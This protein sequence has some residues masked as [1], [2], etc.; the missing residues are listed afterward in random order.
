MVHPDSRDMPVS[1]AHDATT[2]VL[3][4]K[5]LRKS[6][7]LQ[8]TGDY[9]RPFGRRCIVSGGRR[10]L[11]VAGDALC[12]S[13]DASGVRVGV[14]LFEGQ[15][16]QENI[17]TIVATCLDHNAE[18]VVGVGGGR[19]LDSAK[20]AA[21]ALR[22][23]II[24]VPTVASTCSAATPAVVLYDAEGRF[25]R[26]MTLPDAPN[27]VMVDP[28]LIADAPVEYFTP[29][30]LDALSKWYEME[31]I[32]AH[33][34]G[35]DLHTNGAM[36]LAL[37]LRDTVHEKGVSAIE[38]V[39]R[40]TVTADLLEMIDLC[41]YQTAL[42]KC[43]SLSTLRIG[44]AHAVY[45]ALTCVPAA[46]SHMHGTIVGYGMALQLSAL[47]SGDEALRPVLALFQE[48]GSVPSLE[49]L[50]VSPTRE[51]TDLLIERCMSDPGIGAMPQSITTATLQYAIDH[52]ESLA[53]RP[54]TR[55]V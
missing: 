24:C 3:P 4:A 7:I 20:A 30:I 41:I 12:E 9:V 33:M 6:G 48:L 21:S 52:V 42:I 37:L 40:N 43:L 38:A 25:D 26:G 16:C 36:R 1:D 35:T 18:V 34:T 47:E 2:Q 45:N 54:E 23:P 15:C 5:Y 55:A 31:P 28:Q 50:G 13:L 44:V 27:L 14:H 11:A 29:G 10:A 51:I 46:R 32:Y 19:S 39:R 17:D 49:N 8:H 22:V 53:T